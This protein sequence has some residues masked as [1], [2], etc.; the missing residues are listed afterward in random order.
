LAKVL[1]AVFATEK[2]LDGY[3]PKNTVFEL[4]LALNDATLLA[5]PLT[6]L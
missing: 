5:S 1:L 3:V 6:I 4:V 2:L